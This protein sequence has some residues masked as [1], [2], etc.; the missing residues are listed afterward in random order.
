M[1]L[2]LLSLLIY[3]WYIWVP[4]VVAILIISTMIKFR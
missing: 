4:I 1:G 3:Y 2:I